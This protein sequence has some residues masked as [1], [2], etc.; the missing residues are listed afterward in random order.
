MAVV[1]SQM[2]SLPS[3]GQIVE[4]SVVHGKGNFGSFTVESIPLI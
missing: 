3:G 2:M 4:D 1:L